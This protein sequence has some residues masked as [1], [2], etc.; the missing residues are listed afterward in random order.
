MRRPTSTAE[1]CGKLPKDLHHLSQSYADALGAL[2]AFAETSLS[3]KAQ[4]SAFRE[5]LVGLK[6]TWAWVL[7]TT[8]P[9]AS[10]GWAAIHGVQNQLTD[11]CARGIRILQESVNAG[12]ELSGRIAPLAAAAPHEGNLTKALA[13][14]RWIEDAA[15][16]LWHAISGTPDAIKAFVND[17]SWST[18]ADMTEDLSVD[19]S[20]IVLA[21]TAPEA[22][23]GL[24]PDRR[25]GGQQHP[26][27]RLGCQG[28]GHRSGDRDGR[29][30][31]GVQRRSGGVRRRRDRS[32]H[33]R[34]RHQDG[35]GERRARRGPR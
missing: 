33:A 26:R 9:D 8:Y 5:E 10:A 2:G 13:P 20:V 21:A 12:Y 25:R 22:L 16:D 6:R 29:D 14:I 35:P 4:Y 19:A 3:L 30:E 11:V 31:R 7:D 34:D 32:R 27:R 17:P 24:G 18:L 1:R 15:K 23:A 28:C